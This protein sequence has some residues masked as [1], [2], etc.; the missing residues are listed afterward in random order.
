M[1][2]AVHVYVYRSLTTCSNGVNMKRAKFRDSAATNAYKHAGNY[3]ECQVQCSS[4]TSK[5]AESSVSRRLPE[6]QTS[7]F[8][9]TF[10]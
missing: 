7:H 8:C 2:I 3:D 1:Q 6:L 4:D 9:R 5:F 10:S